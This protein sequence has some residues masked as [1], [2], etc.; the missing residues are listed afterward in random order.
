MYLQENTLFYLD[1]MVKVTGNI[2]QY[3]LHNVAYAPVIF[4]VNTSNVL[5]GNAFT[6]KYTI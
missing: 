4:E 1:R 3:P 2:A 5:G 6:R